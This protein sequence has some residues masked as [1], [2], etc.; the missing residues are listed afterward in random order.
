MSD[1]VG[2]HSNKLTNPATPKLL[3]LNTHKET[4]RI[5]DAVK[6]TLTVASKLRQLVAYLS[7]NIRGGT[8]PSPLQSILLKARRTNPKFSPLKAGLISSNKPLQGAMSFPSLPLE[9][10]L[11]VASSAVSRWV[12]RARISARVNLAPDDANADLNS[13]KERNPSWSLKLPCCDTER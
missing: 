4:R 7:V 10:T 5:L 12:K 9:R 11:S 3:L 8:L 2:G 13:L 1:A 6:N